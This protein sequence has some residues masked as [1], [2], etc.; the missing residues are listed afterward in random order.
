MGQR[1]H[2]EVRARRRG[3]R[4]VMGFC[5]KP[6]SFDQIKHPKWTCRHGYATNQSEYQRNKGQKSIKGTKG[7]TPSDEPKNTPRKNAG[8]GDARRPPHTE[9]KEGLPVGKALR[10]LLGEFDHNV[11]MDDMGQF[12]E[13]GHDRRMMIRPGPGP[14]PM[15]K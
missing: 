2:C 14:G 1:K 4:T 7:K 6:R 5:W 8:N 12:M 3:S 10:S 9:G 11:M 15:R 13:P